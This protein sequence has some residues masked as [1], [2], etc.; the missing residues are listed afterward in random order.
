MSR[1][2]T[3]EKIWRDR[4]HDHQGQ[5]LAKW[6]KGGRTRHK[7]KLRWAA[8][9]E[10]AR[11][12]R[13]SKLDAK[14]YRKAK[15]FRLLYEWTRAKTR[16]LKRKLRRARRRRRRDDPD[17]SP[18][19]WGGS[20]AAGERA[21]VEN[22][23]DYGAP[24]TSRKRS[25]SDPLTQQNPDSDHSEANKNAYAWDIATFNGAEL[26]HSIARDLDISGYSTGNYNGY[27]IKRPW[28]TFRT[29]IL[30]AV[31]GHYNHVHVGIRR[32]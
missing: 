1:R 26:A 25:V 6:A 16:R 8:I 31:Q 23:Q 2:D 17:I 12:H 11:D 13:L 15:R 29:Q 14:E 4:Q 20:Q 32:V 19:A 28:G 21:V 27:T 18:Q 5:Y 30:W 10:F 22:A 3:I 24:I 9:A 7:R